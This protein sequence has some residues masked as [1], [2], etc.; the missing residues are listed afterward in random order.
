MMSQ[1][2]A[3]SVFLTVEEQV[4]CGDTEWPK[5]CVKVKAT[6]A[7]RLNLTTIFTLQQQD[8]IQIA[9]CAL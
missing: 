7:M 3:K 6:L 5:K 4:G 9:G 2:L 1:I 8:Y